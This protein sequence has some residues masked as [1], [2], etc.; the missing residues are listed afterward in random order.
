MIIPDVVVAQ[1][2]THKC[3]LCKAPAGETCINPCTQKAMPDR[4]IH[5]YRIE[6]K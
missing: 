5:F 6:P 3:Q 2:L 4:P 1:A